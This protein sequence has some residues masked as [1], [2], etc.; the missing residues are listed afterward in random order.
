MRNKT[1]TQ[2][3]QTV[4]ISKSHTF[5]MM[6]FSLKYLEVWAQGQKYLSSFSYTKVFHLYVKIAP[7]K[8]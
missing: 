6:T 1:N 8:Q 7:Y 5:S 2:H 4:Q 3:P